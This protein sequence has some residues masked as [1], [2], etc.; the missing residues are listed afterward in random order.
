MLVRDIL[1]GIASATPK[2][3]T[4]VKNLD[5]TFL[6]AGDVTT[7]QDLWVTDGT[8]AGTRVIPIGTGASRPG[9]FCVARQGTPRMF[10][11]ETGS[12]TLTR[13]FTGDI[14]VPTGVNGFGAVHLTPAMGGIFPG[15]LLE[16]QFAILDPQ[17]C[18]LNAISVTEPTEG[19]RQDSRRQQNRIRA[20][21]E[22]PAHRA[23][24]PPQRS[25]RRGLLL[26]HRDRTIT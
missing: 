11:A 5:L 16:A 24:L 4:Y 15:T 17:G 7:G 26:R 8:T 9:Y 13:V 6:A 14:G 23:R 19:R 2:D 12:E 10:G 3:L 20:R 18:F 1:P 21:R 22:A 25:R